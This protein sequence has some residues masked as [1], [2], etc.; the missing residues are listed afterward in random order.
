[1]KATTLIKVFNRREKEFEIL[2]FCDDCLD[3]LREA[4]EFGAPT[5]M[6]IADLE[7]PQECENEYC[8]G[9]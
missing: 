1:M 9:R 3:R 6:V 2:A 4:D 7:E 5:Y 8:R